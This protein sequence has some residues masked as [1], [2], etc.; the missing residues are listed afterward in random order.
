MAKGIQHFNSTRFHQILRT[1]RP[2]LRKLTC[3]TNLCFDHMKEFNTN[4]A[5]TEQWVLQGQGLIRKSESPHR[6][7]AFIVRN[8]SEIKRGKTIIVCNYK[9]L[10][11]N[12]GECDKISHPPGF[13]SRR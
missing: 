4:G 5:T 9:R 13:K 10:N 12:T 11:D 1:K 6:S 8:H 3:L 7:V 2:Y